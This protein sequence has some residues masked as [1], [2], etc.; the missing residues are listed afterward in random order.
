MT[1]KTTALF[2]TLAASLSAASLWYWRRRVA[3]PVQ[4]TKRDVAIAQAMPVD[5]PPEAM[6]GETPLQLLSDG[7]G[8]LYVRSYRADIEQPQ[9]T[10]EALMAKIVADLNHYTP[11]EMAHFDKTKGDPDTLAVGD[12]YFITITGPWNGPVRVIAVSPTAF[13]FV[14]LAGHLEAGEISFSVIEHPEQKGMLRFQIQSW[15]RSSNPTTDLFYRV[16][17]VSRFAQTTMWTHFCNEVATNSGGRLADK[18]QVMTHK[19]NAENISQG[20]PG[21]KRYSP[22]FDRYRE[23]K[24]NFDINN[25][26]EFSEANGWRLDD[27][28]TGLPNE[29]PGDPVPH[30]PFESA[31]QIMLNYE[32]PDPTLITGVFVPDQALEDRMMVLRA[33]FLIFTFMFGVRIGKVIDEVRQTE[34]QGAARVWGYSYR[35]LEGH[36]ERGE[37][38]FEVWKYLESGEVRFQIH[39]YSKPTVIPNPAYRLGFALFG[40]SL[41][42]KFA[43][44]SLSRMQQLVLERMAEKTP[45]ALPESEKLDTPTVSPAHTDDAAQ[46]KIENAAPSNVMETP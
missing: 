5:I 36:F 44:T 28:G 21:W 33:R 7:N 4:T 8:P 6:T 37:I 13:S 17:G 23:S 41:Q 18:I 22:Y 31:R 32:F 1:P 3:I 30:G 24:L 20:V 11:S 42:R 34:K 19:V 39:A 9:T 46:E 27:Y 14:T 38:T 16:L 10:P 45:N 43:R 35:T 15:S 12:E 29:A 2:I 26:E 25:T 40:R